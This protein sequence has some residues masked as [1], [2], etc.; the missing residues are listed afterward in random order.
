MVPFKEEGM[1]WLDGLLVLPDEQGRERLVAHY[2]RMKSL[3]ERLEH[4]LVVFNDEREEFEKLVTF[5]LSEVWQCPRSS[6]QVSHRWAGLLLF[7]HTM[8]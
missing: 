6:R 5:A 3:T 1:I 4:G 2:S 7:P 8:A